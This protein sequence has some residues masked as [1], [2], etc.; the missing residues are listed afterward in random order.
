MEGIQ[1]CGAKH[2]CAHERPDIQFQQA[3][4]QL[5]VLSIAEEQG[6]EITII[7]DD[8][9]TVMLSSRQHAEVNLLTYEHLVCADRGFNRENLQMV[10]FEADREFTLAV[11]GDLNDQ[12]LADIQALLR[13]LGGMFKTYLAGE[14]ES[15]AAAVIAESLD[16]FGSLSAFTADFEYRVSLSYL[17][18]EAEQLA[19]SRTG[20]PQRPASLEAQAGIGALPAPFSADATG[21]AA[22][23]QTTVDYDEPQTGAEAVA[24]RM[25]KRSR[26]AGVQG[27]RRLRHLKKFLQ[28]LLK[29]MLSNQILDSGQAQ[30]GQRVIEKFMSALQKPADTGEAPLSRLAL[31]RSIAR[32]AYGAAHAAALDPAVVE[33]G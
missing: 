26:E 10:D 22:A 28:V 23:D 19:L 33:V 2:R 16:R 27:H 1:R 17:N 11:Q 5:K 3:S 9:D 29:V 18:F 7:T 14:D 13:D 12:E 31:N 25:A 30:R 6:S 32:H 24:V 4:T 20:G 15:D 8:G 21:A